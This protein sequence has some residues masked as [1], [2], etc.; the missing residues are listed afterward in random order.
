MKDKVVIIGGG[1]GGLSAAVAL[2]RKGIDWEIYEAAEEIKEVGAGLWLA[3]NALTILEQLGLDKIAYEIGTPYSAVYIEDYKGNKLQKHDVLKTKEKYGHGIVAFERAKLQKLLYD[4]LDK[5]K[6][7]TSKRC[8][9]VLKSDAGLVV[10]F[11]DG[12]EIKGTVVVGA[13]GIKSTVRKY[14]LGEVPFRYSGQTCWRAIVDFQLPNHGEAALSEI[15]GTAK[16]Q[17][18]GVGP[19]SDNKTYYYLTHHAAPNKK[20]NSSTLKEDLL[21]LFN[22][23]SSNLKDLISSSSTDSIIRND[24]SDFKPLKNWVKDNVVLLG[25]AAHSTTPNLGQGACQAIESAYI[26]ADCL[27]S[28]D[29]V[30]MALLAY[31]KKRIDRAAFITN[32]SWQFGKAS[33]LSGI[34][35][36]FIKFSMMKYYPKSLR[37]KQFE[38]VYTL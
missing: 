9:Q 7:N 1:I 25:D 27:H 5:S 14:V 19:V 24:L 34:M 2:D 18:M 4:Q 38:K 10:Q 37:D 11:E 35:G 13:D 31:Q 28:I 12:T 30:E 8:M 29:N 26:L 6:I 33:N 17:R 15:W 22:N 23:Y 3:P 16:G 32:T 20:D 36:N 21:R